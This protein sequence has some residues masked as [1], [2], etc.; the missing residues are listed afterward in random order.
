MP[1]DPLLIADELDKQA[2]TKEDEARRLRDAASV[3]R[4]HARLAATSPDEAGTQPVLVSPAEAFS[5]RTSITEAEY[6]LVLR[7]FPRD[8]EWNAEKLTVELQKVGKPVASV[9]AVRTALG[10][11][12]GK[13]LIRRV[14]HGFYVLD[15]D[16][17][18]GFSS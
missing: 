15:D 5:Q 4:G 8:E 9:D 11:L 13:G 18:G 2:D 6:M 17:T 3:L 16:G 10:R 1:T 7:A 14:R 12:N